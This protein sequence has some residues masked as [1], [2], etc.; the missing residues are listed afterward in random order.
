ML[1]M[2]INPSRE[3]RMGLIWDINPSREWRMDE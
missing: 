3:G 2:L 1:I